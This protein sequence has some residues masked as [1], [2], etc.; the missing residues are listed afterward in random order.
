MGLQ[1]PPSRACRG[2]RRLD[3]RGRLPDAGLYRLHRAFGPNNYGPAFSGTHPRQETS[4][5]AGHSQIRAVDLKP[6]DQWWQLFSE[7]P[8]VAPA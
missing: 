2:L 5:P 8:L 7:A 1:V 3:A 6:L 4:R